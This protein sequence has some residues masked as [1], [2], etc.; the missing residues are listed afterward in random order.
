MSGLREILLSLPVELLQLIFSNLPSRKDIKVLALTSKALYLAFV[1]AEKLIAHQVLRNEIPPD[2]L[3][4]AIAVLRSLQLRR[5]PDFSPA[6]IEPL[7]DKHFLNRAVSLSELTPADILQLSGLQNLVNTF[8][9]LFV[10]EAAT[11]APDGSAELRAPSD[12]ELAR[13]HRAFY[14]YELYSNLFKSDKSDEMI[15]QLGRQRDVFFSRFSPWENEQLAS[16]YDFLART[17]I[18]IFADVA[19]HDVYWGFAHVEWDDDIE[20]PYIQYAVSLGLRRIIC[21]LHANSTLR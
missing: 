6:A 3:P 17:V 11:H 1:D 19:Q 18:P 7:L 15:M 4:E 20:S 12:A 5:S 10:S 13:I 21:I 9:E 2:N 16:I 14:R 8:T